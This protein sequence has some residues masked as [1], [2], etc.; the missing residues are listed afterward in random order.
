MKYLFIAHLQHNKTIM[1]FKDNHDVTKIPLETISKGIATRSDE[2]E[3][4]R[5]HTNT[6]LFRLSLDLAHENEDTP[7]VRSNGKNRM[8]LV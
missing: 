7:V 4:N 3:Q 6:K 1:Q 2:N 5:S 8:L